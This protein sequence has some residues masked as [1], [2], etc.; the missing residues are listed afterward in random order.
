M[1]RL[2]KL[3]LAAALLA[4]VASPVLA[5]GSKLNAAST[6]TTT[7][8]DPTTTGSVNLS[9]DSFLVDMSSST[10]VDLSGFTST[11]NVEFVAVDTLQGWDATKF[12]AEIGKKTT[13]LASL[14]GKIEA[15]AALKSKI[16]AEGH[17]IDDIV[18][19]QNEG[20]SF[21]IYVDDRA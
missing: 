4:G 12:D 1:H 6:A 19:V 15:N 3:G 2:V 21:K 17:Q 14:R 20:G 18:A 10:S 13:D 9:M 8:A 16:E 5:E 7:T 11:S